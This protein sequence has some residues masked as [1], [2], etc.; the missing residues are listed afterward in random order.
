MPSISGDTKLFGLLSHGATFTLS[1]A[2]HNA[3]A[4]SFHKDL[5]YAHFDL[6]AAKVR[7]FL[8]VFWH[9]GGQGL[10]VTMPHKNLVASLV[11]TENLESVNTLVRTDSGWSGYS[12][13][14]EGFLRGLQRSQVAISDFDAV[15]VMG[16]GGSAQAILRAIAAATT[17]RPPITVI[18][19][20]SKNND[21]RILDAV[22]A[23]PVQMLTFRSLDPESFTDTLSQTE[24]LK[25]LIIQA[26]SAPKNGDTLKDYARALDFM[27]AE[28]VLVDL[29]YDNPSDLY[30]SAIARGLRCLD[31]L[32][33]LI[34]QTRLSQFLWWGKAATY[35]EMTHAI[36]Q[37]G[38][39]G[40]ASRTSP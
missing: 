14:G 10:N 37:S 35:E 28:D 16:S 22:S 15:I 13:D 19:R 20:R 39:Q 17:E 40:R 24:G 33:M 30:F 3:A 4:R 9:M 2:M 12:T 25:R 29:I 5:V 38:W 32:P 7:E 21:Q 23:A 27:S 18:H 11:K 1:P 34:E 31:G 26:T 36:K 6:P 8:D